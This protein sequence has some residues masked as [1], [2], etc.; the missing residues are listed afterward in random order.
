M[1]ALRSKVSD[2][3]WFA[4]LAPLAL[5]AI[6]RSVSPQVNYEE[7]PVVVVQ[8]ASWESSTSSV[9]STFDDRLRSAFLLRG[10]EIPRQAANGMPRV[11]ERNYNNISMPFANC[12]KSILLRVW[13]QQFPFSNRKL[14]PS[15]PLKSVKMA[16]LSCCTTATKHC[17]AK[18]VSGS[19]AVSAQRRTCRPSCTNLCRQ[20]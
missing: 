4:C 2:F 18:G 20:A 1:R 12:W 17:A 10:W 13:K 11:F 6:L 14:T 16:S 15:G 9:T 7:D 19:W 8:V 3:A 5:L